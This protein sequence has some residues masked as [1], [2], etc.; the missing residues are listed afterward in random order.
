MR[1]PDNH[2]HVQDLRKK[3]EVCA[4]KMAPSKQYI[5]A[6]HSLGYMA[7]LHAGLQSL[8]K[9]KDLKLQQKQTH[10]ES[11]RQALQQQEQAYQQELDQLDQQVSMVEEQIQTMQAQT[12]KLNG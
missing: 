8:N 12:D 1:L 10:I 7:D 5:C 6:K 4:A 3:L 11:L 2:W 9:L